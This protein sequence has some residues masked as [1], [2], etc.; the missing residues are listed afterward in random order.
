MEEAGVLKIESKYDDYEIEKAS[1]MEN[2]GKYDHFSFDE[3]GS[4]KMETAY[5]DLNI[6][7]LKNSA[8]IELKYGNIEI[9]DI[10]KGF[11][12]VNIEAE[13]AD[14]KLATDA[15]CMVSLDATHGAISVPDDLKENAQIEK[16]DHKTKML[17]GK[18]GSGSSSASIQVAIKFGAIK[19]ED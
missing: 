8:G 5:T 9:G 14:I 2:E 15:D 10:Q 7:E 4:V 3:L 1:S 19:L 18:M 16:E 12:N 11:T 13:F 6:D 17:K